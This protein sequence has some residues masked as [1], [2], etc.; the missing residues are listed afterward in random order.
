MGKPNS[1]K[2]HIKRLLEKILS[3]TKFM[4]KT[5]IEM[6]RLKHSKLNLNC[7]YWWQT[8]VYRLF[9]KQSALQSAHTRW[10]RNRTKFKII[11]MAW[12]LSNL[13]L[14]NLFSF[15][16]VNIGIFSFFYLSYLHVLFSYQCHAWFARFFSK[17]FF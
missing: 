4:S 13:K 16:K 1:K 8:H 6:Q 17:I 3:K 5:L 9:I 7:P 15:P 14:S 2:T 10:K 12:W 11:S